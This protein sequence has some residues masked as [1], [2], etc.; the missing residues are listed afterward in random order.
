[1]G[2][3]Y[4]VKDRLIKGLFVLL[5]LFAFGVCRFL[6]YIIVLVQF[7]FDLISGEPNTRLC[8]FSAELKDY[9]SEIIT[10]VTY[11]SDTK[12]FPFSDW[13]KN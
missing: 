10:F 12:P 1:M 5:F 8:Q 7:L 13:P 11:Q 6:L 4:P 9:F 3:T 2:E